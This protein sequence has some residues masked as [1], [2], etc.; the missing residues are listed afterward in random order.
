M[1]SNCRSLFLQQLIPRTLSKSSIFRVK[2][3]F[4]SDGKMEI[5]WAAVHGSILPPANGGLYDAQTW[6]TP[7]HYVPRM[8]HGIA[9]SPTILISS[10]LLLPSQGATVGMRPTYG[11][12]GGDMIGLYLRDGS[13]LWK[14][15]WQVLALLVRGRKS[16]DRNISDLYRSWRQ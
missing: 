6:L 1:C 8:V 2:V 10:T 11:L 9:V 16:S 3:S 5:S 7:I 12:W 14:H 13:C 4:T 15:S